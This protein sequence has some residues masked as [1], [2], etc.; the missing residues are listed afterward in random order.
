MSKWGNVWQAVAASVAAAAE[1]DSS[2]F[3]PGYYRS[4]LPQV[5][6]GNLLLPKMFRCTLQVS[7]T[8]SQYSTNALILVA[9][10]VAND[11]ND[12]DADDDNDENF[13]EGCSLPK[14]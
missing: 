3:G 4:R 9:V 5:G 7:S 13:D 6:A 10:A 8:F 12:D 11:D 14:L 1:E 2:C